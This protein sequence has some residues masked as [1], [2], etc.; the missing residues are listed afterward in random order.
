MNTLAQIAA[1]LAV[2]AAGLT[3]FYSLR[4]GRRFSNSR[5]HG[6]ESESR[7]LA[8]QRSCFQETLTFLHR[9]LSDSEE[10]E[11]SHDAAIDLI[12]L[13]KASPR[14]SFAE[15]ID[16]RVLL[17]IEQSTQASHIW[18]VQSDE[19]IEFE[20]PT[21]AV[22]FSGAVFE[23]LERGVVYR[24]LVAQTDTTRNRARRIFDIVSKGGFEDQMEI[25]F[26]PAPY[27]EQMWAGKSAGWV[28][29]GSGKNLSLFYRF[30]PLGSEPLRKWI[31]VPPQEAATRLYDLETMWSSAVPASKVLEDKI[32]SP[33][34]KDGD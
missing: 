20:Y 21:T 7:V 34:Q 33:L 3:A 23:N 22:T 27:W 5:T 16:D 15:V 9:A 6:E 24:Y 29:Y 25:R 8:D 19:S 11:E 31:R 18:V 4:E 30:P 28:A 12:E 2:L 32:V 10:W 13:L 26:L 14:L 1:L 17:S